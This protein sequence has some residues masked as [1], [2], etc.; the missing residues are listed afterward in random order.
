MF[1]FWKK[2]W[3]EK[4]ISTFSDLY[5]KM[6]QTLNL[7]SDEINHFSKFHLTSEPCF[8]SQRHDADGQNFSQGGGQARYKD[9]GNFL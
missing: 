7:P 5:Q 8:G 4:I 9:E 6:I 3:L 2:H 1:V